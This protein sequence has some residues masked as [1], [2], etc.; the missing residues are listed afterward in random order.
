MCLFH[1]RRCAL[2][3]QDQPCSRPSCN[4]SHPRRLLWPLTLLPTR[5]PRG[6][7]FGGD[8]RAKGPGTCQVIRTLE[9]CKKF[10]FAAGPVPPSIAQGWGHSGCQMSLRD[11]PCLWIPL[12]SL[13]SGFL[14]SPCSGNPMPAHPAAYTYTGGLALVPTVW[15]VPAPTPPSV[16][17]PAGSPRTRGPGPE[18][19]YNEITQ[20]V[21][22]SG[23][24]YRA[25]APPRLPG[26]RKNK[27]GECGQRGRAGRGCP[28]QC[29]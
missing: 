22:H 3:W 13:I 7:T 8:Q 17:C 5:W 21:T 26:A 14:W 16:L 10:L 1:P 4:S 2:Q 29:H 28:P 11:S 25:T 20:P 12:E 6:P 15:W 27:E 23:F 19:V 18:G 9:L 24:L